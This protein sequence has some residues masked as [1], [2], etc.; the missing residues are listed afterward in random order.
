MTISPRW[1]GVSRPLRCAGKDKTL[2]GLSFWRQL[3]LR[4]RISEYPVTTF[5]ISRADVDA[6]MAASRMAP[7]TVAWPPLRVAHRGA[8]PRMS[9]AG[10]AKPGFA[11]PGFA[12]PGLAKP[13]LAKPGLA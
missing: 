9:L 5:A 2:V 11:K 12:K 3:W 7:P 10:A 8:A 13:G 6:A 4:D 1:R